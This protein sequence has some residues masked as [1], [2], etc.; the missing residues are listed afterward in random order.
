MKRT[1]ANVTVIITRK[2]VLI[3]LLLRFPSVARNSHLYHMV[4]KP[5]LND[6]AAASQ[7]G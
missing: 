2:C 1:N 4:V 7:R 3:T 5:S 6:I